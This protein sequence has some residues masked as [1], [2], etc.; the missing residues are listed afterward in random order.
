MRHMLETFTDRV[1]KVM[2]H[3][4]REAYLFNH[5]Y[6]D[7]AHV[8]LGLIKEE[9]GV[10]FEVLKK[11][12]FDLASIR[13]ETENIVRAQP[14]S[15]T[16][17]TIRLAP[18]AENIVRYASEEARTFNKEFVGTEHLLL[19]LLRE[20]VGTGAK[21]LM[22]Q[23]S[24]VKIRD[25][26]RTILGQTPPVA[27]ETGLPE[28]SPKPELPPHISQLEGLLGMAIDL[29]DEIKENAIHR[30]YFERAAALQEQQRQIKSVQQWL[31]SNKDVEEG[32]IWTATWE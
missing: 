6:I 16:S 30:Q 17:G 8:L 29:L 28:V 22:R 9:T 11:L 1:R 26:I 14:I 24:L 13:L 15:V 27:T 18:A 12:G 20:E 25:E 2:Q 19:G 23:F 21:V 10:A 5:N 32:E 4:K 3:A 31:V 7:T